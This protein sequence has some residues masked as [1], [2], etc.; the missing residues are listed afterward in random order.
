[1]GCSDYFHELRCKASSRHIPPLL[2]SLEMVS[3]LITV[4]PSTALFCNEEE[5]QGGNEEVEELS[6]SLWIPRHLKDGKY[7]DPSSR[8]QQDVCAQG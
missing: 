5:W 2:I 7:T 3:L 6:G 4:T 1:M 8:G